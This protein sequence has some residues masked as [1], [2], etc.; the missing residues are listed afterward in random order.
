MGWIQNTADFL[1][2]TTG[3][4]LSSATGGLFNGGMTLWNAIQNFQGQKQNQYN[5]EHQYEIAAESAERAGINKATISSGGNPNTYSNQSFNPVNDIGASVRDALVSLSQLKKDSAE[6]ENIKAQTEATLDSMRRA[7]IKDAFDMS[8]AQNYYG[9]DYQKFNTSTDQW[10]KNFIENVRQFNAKHALDESKFENSK[11]ESQRDYGLAL[12]KYF[13]DV[14]RNEFDKGNILWNQQFQQYALAQ[15]WNKVMAQL[16]QSD[17]NS[18]RSSRTAIGTS[19]MNDMASI[20]NT[21][22][23]LGMMYLAPF[24]GLLL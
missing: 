1:G 9:L 12:S 6:T 18:K 10:N 20:T 4:I 15:D 17:T 7:N 21:A 19:Y 11:Y 2:S 16:E 8:M 3:Q 23:R 14:D 24:G 22:L 13:L 5:L